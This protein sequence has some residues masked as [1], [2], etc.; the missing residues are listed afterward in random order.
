MCQN[1]QKTWPIANIS[2]LFYEINI[3]ENDGDDRI[4]TGST[5][6]GIYA[7][8]QKEVVKN[9]S[10]CYLIIKISTFISSWGLLNQM[11]LSNTRKFLFCTCTLKYGEKQQNFVKSPKFWCQ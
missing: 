7:Q 10:K 6:N 5:S 4:R 9:G 2:E 8:A 3:V 1:Q 11:A